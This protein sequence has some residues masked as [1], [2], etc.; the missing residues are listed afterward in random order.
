[1]TDPILL[2]GNETCPMIPPVRDLLARA[3]APYTYISITRD[4]AA[5]A[6][7]QQINHGNAS[8][9]T[10]V[11][12]DGSTLTEP[13]LAELSARLEALG[14][15]VRPATR[16]ERLTLVLEDRMI[17]TLSIVFLAI[18]LLWN[19][20]SLAVAGAVLLVAVLVGK[21]L[22]KSLKD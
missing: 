18:G 2:Y 9:P 14:Y 8:V 21:G 6:R 20:P 13:K 16:L 3:A 11:F 12:P 10:L 5:R 15:P 19:Q 17:S 1:M 22:R 4:R 7:V